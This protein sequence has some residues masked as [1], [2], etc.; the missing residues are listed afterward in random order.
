MKTSALIINIY[1][2]LVYISSAFRMASL[3][4]VRNTF[5]TRLQHLYT[6]L[7]VFSLTAFSQENVFQSNIGL[8]PF[9]LALLRVFLLFVY[10]TGSLVS[11]CILFWFP[12]THFNW[13]CLLRF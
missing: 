1:L 12:P 6:V 7:F 13:F 8:V 3:T 5:I 9:F 11:V 4:F 2:I 10:K